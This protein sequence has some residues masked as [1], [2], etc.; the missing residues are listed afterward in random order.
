MAEFIGPVVEWL[1]GVIVA[2]TPALLQAAGLDEFAEVRPAWTGVVLNWP[3]CSVYP[4]KTEFDPEG[5]S[6]HSAHSIT[7]KFGVSGADPDQVVR[8]AE[9]YMKAIDAAIAGAVGEWLP[10]ISKVFVRSHEYGPLWSGKGFAK[11]PELVVEV[12]TYE[13]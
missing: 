9:A 1:I 7:I 11:F 5:T 6:V 10:A 3:T 8:D 12:E 4:G 13:V 2:R